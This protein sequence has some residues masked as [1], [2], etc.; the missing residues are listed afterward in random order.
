M[1]DRGIPKSYR[2]MHGFGS[3]TYSFINS[4]NKRFWV[5]FTFKTQ[6]GTQKADCSA[7][8]V[9]VHLCWRPRP[10]DLL[11]KKPKAAA[12]LDRARAAGAG[13]EADS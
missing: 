8:I 11:I 12:G 1:G 4:E 5:K 7:L 6:Q 9:P 13:R 3:H 2:Y 10:Q